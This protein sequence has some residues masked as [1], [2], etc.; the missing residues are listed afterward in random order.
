[1]LLLDAP[2]CVLSPTV[3]AAAQPGVATRP[4][5]TTVLLA[6]RLLWMLEKAIPQQAL[7]ITTLLVTVTLV[8]SEFEGVDALQIGRKRKLRV[9][10]PDDHVAVDQDVLEMVD[11]DAWRQ[12]ADHALHG[13][14]MI[15]VA[16]VQVVMDIVLG[17]GEIACRVINSVVA[18]MID[19]V[20]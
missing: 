14:F 1:M 2:S 20:V 9:G 18:K 13:V 4:S 15:A 3:T 5:S 19:L 11:S 7:V 8:Q 6:I 10:L 16:D 17:D 12:D